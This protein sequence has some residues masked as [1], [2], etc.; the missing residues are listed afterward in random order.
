VPLR[1]IAE[2][3]GRGLK[4]RSSPCRLKRPSAISAGWACSPAWT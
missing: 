2:S 4:I 1:E 3:I